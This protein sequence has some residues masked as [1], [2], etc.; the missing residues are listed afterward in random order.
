MLVTPSTASDGFP[1]GFPFAFA[2]LW[3]FVTYVLAD[4]SGWRILARKYATDSKPEGQ[5]FRR[6]VYKFGE[7]PEN[8]VTTLVVSQNG[9]Y[10]APFILFRAGRHPIMIPWRAVTGVVHGQTWW[11]HDWYNL[12]VEGVTLIRVGQKAFD[13]MAA[14]LPPPIEAAA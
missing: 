2:A 14:F 4:K 8:G 5:R 1:F 11:G 3:F 12:N 7:V 9:L 6:Q 13:S 10:L